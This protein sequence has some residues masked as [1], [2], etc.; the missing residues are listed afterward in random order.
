MMSAKD[1]LGLAFTALRGHPVRTS[2]C[3]TGV[4][5]GVTAVLVLTALGEGARRY[6]INEFS[7]IGTNLLLGHTWKN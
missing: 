2:L 4:S 1:Y 7:A 6:V 5:I 3:V